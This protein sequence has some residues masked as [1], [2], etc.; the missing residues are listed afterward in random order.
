[1]QQIESRRGF[2]IQA[3]EE[4]LRS[5]MEGIL[6]ELHCQTKYRGCL[7]ELMSQL[8][9]IQSHQHRPPHLDEV[10]VEDIKEHLQNEHQ[11]IEHLLEIIKQDEQILAQTNNNSN[12]QKTTKQRQNGTAG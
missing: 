3:D 11:G 12:D 5:R 2:P 6:S 9:Q 1:M 4:K 7:N 8:K 10:I